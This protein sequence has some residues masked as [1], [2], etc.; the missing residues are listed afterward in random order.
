MQVATTL[1]GRAVLLD[2]EPQELLLD[3]LRDRFGLTGAKR[4]CEVQVCG[5]CT[6]LLDGLPVSACTVL[7]ADTDG[8]SILTI[9]GLRELD[10]FPAISDAFE[11]HAAVQCG[12]CSPAMALTIHSLLESGDLVDERSI[13]DGLSGN[14][15][16]CT[17]YRG[18]L[19]AAADLA[20][21]TPSDANVAT[22]QA[23]PRP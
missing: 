17:G 3:C 9:E 4:S 18:I 8:R 22:H 10:A 16:R 6:V 2:V 20:G 5:T 12:F 7:V 1:N 11:R 21:V 13:R 14:L 23:E 15:C 19:A